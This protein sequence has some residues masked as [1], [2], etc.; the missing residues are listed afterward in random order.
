MPAPTA[1]SFS[2]NV[3]IVAQLSH[4]HRLGKSMTTRLVRKGVELPP[5]ATVRSYDYDYQVGVAACSCLVGR[6][7]RLCRMDGVTLA[8]G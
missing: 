5:I 6:R 7:S 4:M 8:T 1:P 2:S 3:K